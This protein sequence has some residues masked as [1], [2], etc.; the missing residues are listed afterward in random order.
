MG[1]VFIFGDTDN[2]GR[3][4]VK[5]GF[6]GVTFIPVFNPPSVSISTT[7]RRRLNERQN[8]TCP[9]H[10]PEISPAF[11]LFP[12]GSRTGENTFFFFFSGAAVRLGDSAGMTSFK[13]DGK[14]RAGGSSEPIRVM[15]ARAGEDTAFEAGFDV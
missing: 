6:L 13:D 5:D 12:W 7:F 8:F 14:R 4:A 10:V 11:P 2:R 3:G 9:F 1:L 15:R